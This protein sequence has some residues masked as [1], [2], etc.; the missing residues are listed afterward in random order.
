MLEDKDYVMRIVHEWIRTLIKLIFNKDI[1]KEEDAEIPLEVM[2]QFRKLNAM[3]D[4]GE[5]NEAENILLDGLR[6]GDRTYFE[7]SLLFYEKLSGKT[8]EFLAEHDYSR[9]EVVD[10][11]KYGVNYYGYGS[12]LEA[13]AEDIEISQKRDGYTGPKTEFVEKYTKIVKMK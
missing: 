6:E 11:L 10:G 5:I 7:M 1:D 8:D 12:L 3:I 13:F 9:E 4:D 2:E